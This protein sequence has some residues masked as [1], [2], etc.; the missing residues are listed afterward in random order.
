MS[1]MQKSYFTKP[2][3]GARI[4]RLNPINRGLLGWWLFN[5]GA[6]SRIHDSSG[7]GNHGIATTVN[8]STAW[9]GSPLGKSFVLNGSSDFITITPSNTLRPLTSLSIVAIVNGTGADDG[10]SVVTHRGITTRVS[11]SI[12]NTT[13]VGNRM[14]NTVSDDG[15]L[16]ASNHKLW[17]NSAGFICF[18][19]TWHSVVMTFDGPTSTFLM[20]IDG[21]RDRGA[22]PVANGNIKFLHDSTLN[23]Y[24][25]C[26]G[27]E[28]KQWDGSFSDVKMYDRALSNREIHTLNVNPYGGLAA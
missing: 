1:K 2:R 3:V 25:G 28:T 9:G 11:W 22:I 18:D 24:F 27:D 10:N 8:S 12:E 19:K 16:G 15:T 13:I 26:R 4:E 23:L 14:L 21:R 7:N 20:Y 6:G 17:R 5:E